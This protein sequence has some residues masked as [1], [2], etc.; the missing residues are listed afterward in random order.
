MEA[1][2]A[3]EDAMKQGVES[4]LFVWALRAIKHD[5]TLSISEAINLA[6]EEWI[7]A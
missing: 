6:R 1:H 4:E 5:D 3:L 2:H 7:K